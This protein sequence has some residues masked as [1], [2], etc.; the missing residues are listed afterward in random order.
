MENTMIDAIQSAVEYDDIIRAWR[1]AVVKAD[2]AGRVML[3]D[4]L[5]HRLGRADRECLEKAL[6]PVIKSRDRVRQGVKHEGEVLAHHHAHIFADIIVLFG[7]LH[8]RGVPT[9]ERFEREFHIGHKAEYGSYNL[10]YIGTIVQI[11]RSSVTIEEHNGSRHRL[12]LYDFAWRNWDF[13]AKQREKA[14]YEAMS[15][16]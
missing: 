4:A 16:M 8:R 7:E 15:C 12:S 2:D 11:G 9:G 10:S 1:F 14:N 6:V 13:D 5:E 3:G